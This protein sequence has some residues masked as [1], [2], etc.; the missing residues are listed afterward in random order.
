VFLPVTSGRDR[1]DVSA[2]KPKPSAP[3]LES[4]FNP[5]LCWVVDV[6]E[7]GRSWRLFRGSRR[8]IVNTRCPLARPSG[9]NMGVHAHRPRAR[10][11]APPEG[12][13]GAGTFVIGFGYIC[14]RTRILMYPDVSCVYPEGY[15]YRECILMYL[16]CILNALPKCSVV[17]EDN[18]FSLSFCMYFVMYPSESVS[19]R[20]SFQHLARLRVV[21]FHKV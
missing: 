19:F 18:T 20:G 21:C 13:P 6:R 16:K 1:V 14:Y 8:Q 17:F 15:M 9:V 10:R 5:A 7:D 2:R 11:R 3:C 4:G 12:G